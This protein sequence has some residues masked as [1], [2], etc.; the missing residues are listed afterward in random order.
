MM[1]GYRTAL[2][3]TLM[4]LISATSLL[5]HGR[6]WNFLGY[7][8]FDGNRDHGAIE[9]RRSD[10]VF[11]TIQLRFRGNAI[12]FERLLIHFGNGASQ[13]LVVD[14]RISPEGTE[15]MVELPD[16]GRALESIEFWYFKEHWDRNPSVSLYGSCLPDAAA[17]SSAGEH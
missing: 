16:N 6:V 2:L 13:E 12:F 15:Y 5:A 11:R 10:R 3:T 8:K 17:K 1:L 4:A 7:T 14:A 9:I